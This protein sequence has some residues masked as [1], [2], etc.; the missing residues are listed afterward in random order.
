MMSGYDFLKSQV[1]R[2]WQ[3]AD[4]DWD[5]VM[6]SGSVFQTRGPATVKARLPT[7]E[8]L[9]GGTSRPEKEVCLYT[10]LLVRYVRG[11]LRHVETTSIWSVCLQL[12]RIDSW[13][14]ASSGWPTY[15]PR[16]GHRWPAARLSLDAANTRNVSQRLR[17][18]SAKLIH[19][20]PD[21]GPNLHNFVECTY[22][23]V[24]RELRL[25]S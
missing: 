11:C 8:S 5:V 21:L 9:T 19:T 14:P 12:L 22:E 15:W 24:T 3:N 25:V 2:R 23:N 18:R 7:V 6:S 1:L 20:E 17:Q 16:N 13:Q 10:V 4:S